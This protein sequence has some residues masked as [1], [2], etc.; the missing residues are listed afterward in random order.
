VAGVFVVDVSLAL[1]PT[2]T[3]GLY[4]RCK[5]LGFGVANGGGKE[6]PKTRS[7][8]RPQMFIKR[9]SE[10]RSKAWH[11]HRE[12]DTR[13][14]RKRRD[15]ATATPRIPGLLAPRDVTGKLFGDK[16]NA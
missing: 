4:T 13:S 6:K 3:E 11:S 5:A 15:R 14:K 8:N 10:R 7:A 1:K 12:G 2:G 9:Y 16:P